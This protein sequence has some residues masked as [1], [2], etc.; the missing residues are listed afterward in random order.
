MRKKICF[1]VN[2]D[3]YEALCRLCEEKELTRGAL[4]LGLLEDYLEKRRSDFDPKS[5]GGLT[6]VPEPFATK[7]PV[8][9]GGTHSF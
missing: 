4:F 1:L 3:Q 7:K 9:G 8:D 6:K 5:S 2:E